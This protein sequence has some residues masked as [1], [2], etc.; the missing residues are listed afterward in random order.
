MRHQALCSTTA[1][2]RLGLTEHATRANHHNKGH[3]RTSLA[4]SA[5]NGMAAKA[6][7]VPVVEHRERL[8]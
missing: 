1:L 3:N 7:L 6:A 2:S 4:R 5:V 8:Q